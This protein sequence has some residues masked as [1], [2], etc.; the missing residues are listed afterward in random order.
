MNILIP[1]GGL[2]SRFLETG[3]TLPKP[4]IN[5]LLKPI[6]FWLLDCLN[7]APED[8]VV[9]ICNKRLRQ[10]RF[11]E[12]VN[13]T[14][15]N[16]DVVYLD[17]DTRGAAETVLCGLPEI[18]LSK[19]VILLDGDT[20]YTVDILNLYRQSTNKNTVFSFKQQ[21]SRAIYSYVRVSDGVIKQIA[22]KQPISDLANTG[23]Y[24]FESGNVLKQYCEHAIDNFNETKQKEL[25]TSTIISDMLNDQHIFNCIEL[26]SEDF[27]VVGTPL[28]YKLFHNK[29]KSNK[30]YFNQFRICFDLDNTLVNHP[31]KPGDYSTVRP[32][33]QNIQYARFLHDLGCTIIIYT[34]RRMKT[35]NGNVGSIVADVGR[36]TIDTIE[37]YNIPCDELYF[38]KPYA[39]AYIDDLAYN[40]FDDYPSMLGL[41]DHH[42]KERDFNTVRAKNLQVFEKK[43]INPYKLQA[44]VFWYE[45]IPS[46]VKCHTPR[47]L[48]CDTDTNS[49][50]TEKIDGITFSE[51]IVSQSLSES[52]FLK[53]IETIDQ[54]HQHKP[55]KIDFDVYSL[56]KL[57]LKS[58]Y[59]THDYTSHRNIQEIYD[60]LIQQFD[61]YQQTNR[62]I[63]GCI[64]GDPVFSNV[65]IDKDSVIKLVDPR[66]LTG[67]DRLC[68]YGDV[69]YDYAKIL[70]S[71][72]GYDEILLTGDRFLDNDALVRLLFQHIKKTYGE[73]YIKDIKTIKNSLLL[74]LIPLHNNNNCS[75][76]YDLIEFDE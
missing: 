47:L 61:I 56:Y 3:Y 18:D 66:G 14:Y 19:P 46:D 10:Y 12:L 64:H 73:Q 26:N 70:Q 38:G 2:G 63:V 42:V 23:A 11:K 15:K 34:A 1:I 60:K 48:S 27:E 20:F 24:A 32:I 5:L 35:H 62:S 68:I 36:V 71:L 51:L 59:E 65:L 8:R 52:I 7:L 39:H 57:K 49:Y 45:N 28:Q 74:T 44:E 21:D 16:V 17:R 55:K 50:L 6:V 30:E 53:L 13:K 54:F 75:K 43:S 40:A 4:L 76:F 25:Y 41:T 22:E 31:D 67:D 58:R 72:C 9:I 33:E 29:N 69:M 37:E